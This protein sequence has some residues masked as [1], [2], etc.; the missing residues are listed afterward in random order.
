[1]T[2]LF[3]VWN[4]NISHDEFMEKGLSKFPDNKSA[5]DYWLNEL[6]K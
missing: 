3:N 6:P 5:L 4:K 1:M 2:L